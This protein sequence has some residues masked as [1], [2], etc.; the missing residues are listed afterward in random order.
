[1][2]STAT[3]SEA[4]QLDH[5]PNELLIRVFSLLSRTELLWALPLVCRAFSELLRSPNPFWTESYRLWR[6]RTFPA[7]VNGPTLC[8]WLLPR[9]HELTSFYCPLGTFLPEQSNVLAQDLL[10]VLPT[11]LTNLRF[12]CT[13]RHETHQR[14]CIGRPHSEQSFERQLNVVPFLSVLTRLSNLRRLALPLLENCQH[15]LQNLA[16]V[17]TLQVLHLDWRP[18][19][20]FKPRH[21]NDA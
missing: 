20:L 14:R 18:S 12:L 4:S 11:T 8:S 6:F 21:Q 7:K 9:L 16:A 10:S 1:M 5:L 15:S 2:Q 17:K 13:S 3:S 19:P